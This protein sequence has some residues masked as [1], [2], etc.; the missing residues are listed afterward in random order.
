LKLISK[1]EVNSEY[2]V[3]GIEQESSEKYLKRL[4]PDLAIRYQTLPPQNPSSLFFLLEG[5]MRASFTPSRLNH[6]GSF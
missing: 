3:E 6:Y 2:R 5:G 1:T 4:L